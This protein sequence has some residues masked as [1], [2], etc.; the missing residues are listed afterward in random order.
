ML[1]SLQID[2][3]KSINLLLVLFHNKIPSGSFKEKR[4]VYDVFESL[5]SDVTEYRML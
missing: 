3:A 5:K 2:I 4:R 1:L